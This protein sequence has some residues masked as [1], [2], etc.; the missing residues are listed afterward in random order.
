MVSA[1]TDKGW[2]AWTAA[3]LVILVGVVFIF[4]VFSNNLFEVGPAFEDLIDDFRPILTDESLDTA[5]ADVAGLGAV[6]TEF[7]TAVVPGMAQALQMTPQDFG[8]MMQTNFPA[9]ATGAAALP[10]IETQFSSVLGTLRAEQDRFASADAIPTEDLPATTVPWGLFLAG[11]ATLLVG[12]YMIY[13]IKM[14][15]MVAMGLGVV[16]VVVPLLL[17][18]VGKAGDADELN[19]NLEPV[20]TQELVDGAKGALQVVGAMGT[21]MQTAMLPTLA[22]QLEMAPDQLNAFL[23]ENF[24][25]TAGVLANLDEVSQR[26]DGLVT[27][28]D[29]NLD[30]YEVLK[31]VK[32][33]P[34]IWTIIIG[35][36]ALIALGAWGFV[37]ARKT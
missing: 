6:A 9:V 5:D 33:T 2:Q 32:F 25:A 19:E 14:G 11:I 27:T 36:V 28:F 31:P 7:E 8:A 35:G 18:L 4:S 10:D 21:E 13:K 3:A 30:N 22:T 37:T 23:G 26:F 20:Y 12:G 34:I 29:E 17:S 16:L 24:P 1:I 15:S